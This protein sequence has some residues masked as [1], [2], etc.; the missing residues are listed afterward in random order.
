MRALAGLVATL[1][2]GNA[3]A[4]EAAPDLGWLAGDWVEAKDGRVSEESWMAP[5][6]GML[7]GM[8]RTGKAGKRGQ[9]E[10]MRIEAG[11][12]GRLGFIAQ[13][14]GAP[15]AAFHLESRGADAIS[16]LNAAHDYP[17]RI[18]YWREGEL[19]MAEISLKDGSK[20]HRWRYARKR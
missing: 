5:R 18:R 17:Q 8:S 15:P 16:F 4:Q 11:L 1:V 13:P 7:I 19:L 9:F 20:A 2:A 12:D 14:N 10:F 3:I 6:G